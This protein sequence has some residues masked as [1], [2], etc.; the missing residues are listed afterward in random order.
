MSQPSNTSGVAPLGRAVLVKYYEPE[1][2]E[3]AIYIPESIRKGE[4][5]VE[6]R[7]TVVEVGP[8]CWPDEPARA[9]PGDRVLIAAMS[10]YAL[11]GPA[12]GHLYRIVNDRDIFAQITH[13]EG[14]A[15]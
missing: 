4:V 9:K 15:V 6:Q 5:L 14:G 11:K 1:R 10:G 13:D 2:K 12:D 8:A 3:S 7:A